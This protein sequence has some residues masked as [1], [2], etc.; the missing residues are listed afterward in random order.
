[1]RE[2]Y[3]QLFGGLRRRRKLRSQICTERD[4]LYRIAWSWCH[5]SY[6]A[7]DL[8]QETLVRA[9]AKVG[10]LREENRLQVWLTQILANLYRDHHRR[11]QP[12]T[13]LE[14]DNLPADDDPE[15]AADR[16]QL[17]V[18]TRQAIELLDDSQRQVL[19]LVDIAEFSYAET[20]SILNVPV[21]TVMSR[22]SRAR[23]RMRE[24]LAQQGI[25]HTDV[26][27]LRRSR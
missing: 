3:D 23:T 15:N 1:M 10:N 20:A 8:V 13:G 25:G 17:L 27:P 21:G 6:Q 26:I 12:D 5:D 18:R 14:S 4:R 9:L 22:L 2:Y 19:T 16:S 11:I 24:I 7:D